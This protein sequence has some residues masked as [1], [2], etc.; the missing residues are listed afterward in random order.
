MLVETCRTLSI[1]DKGNAATSTTHTILSAIIVTPDLSTDDLVVDILR[2]TPDKSAIQ[3]SDSLQLDMP[4]R[5]I[6]TG[7]MAHVEIWR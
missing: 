7:G 2:I 4:C 1:A 6:G 3:T 5:L